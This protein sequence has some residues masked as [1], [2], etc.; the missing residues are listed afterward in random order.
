MPAN[1]AEP[2]DAK[3]ALLWVNVRLLH[4]LNGGDR[5]RTYHMLRQLRHHARVTYFCPQT[6]QDDESAIELAGEY[7]DEL[8]TYSLEIKRSPSAS[9]Y[10]A[11]LANCVFGDLP[12]AAAKYGCAEASAKLQHLLAQRRHDL[13]VADYLM[14]WVHFASLTEPARIPTVV[15][16]HNIESLIWQR[17]VQ[18]LRPGLRR[19]VCRREWQLTR[20]LEDRVAREASGQI[21]VSAQEEEDFKNQR[22]MTNILGWVPTG[23]DCDAFEPSTCEDPCLAFLGSMDWQANVDA[24]LNFTREVLPKI[25][26]KIP[27]TKL[28]LIGRNPTATLRQLAIEDSAIELS[29]TVD[30]VRP[31]LARASIMI[32]PLRV[33]GGTRIKVFEAMAAGLAIVSTSVGVEGLPTVDGQHVLIADEN[34]SFARQTLL[35][36]E[37]PSLRQAQARRARDWVKTHFGWQQAADQ[38]FALLKPLLHNS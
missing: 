11:A 29:G 22:G 10:A 36:L 2:D 1:Q 7:C 12:Y 9:F 20:Q 18:H 38:F 25:R 14:S 26:A 13:A 28:L 35:L 31:W 19:W 5:L 27:N 4:P 37:N 15:F 33:G 3:P 17:H 32:L 34:E 21:M 16:E 30:D 6:P 24:V 8:I 23:V